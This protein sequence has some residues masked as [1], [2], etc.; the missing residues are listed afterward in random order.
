MLQNKNLC[1]QGLDKKRKSDPGAGS[2]SGNSNILV[3]YKAQLDDVQVEEINTPILPASSCDKRE[4]E[5]NQSSSESVSSCSS[6]KNVQN[7]GVEQNRDSS[8]IKYFHS[9]FKR[10]KTV[11]SGSPISSIPDQPVVGSDNR[12]YFSDWKGRFTKKVHELRESKVGRD[13]SFSDKD[14]EF[15]SPE[16]SPTAKS[17]DD[18]TYLSCGDTNNTDDIKSE[19][20]NLTKAKRLEKL[21]LY[22]DSKL[23]SQ[24]GSKSPAPANTNETNEKRTEKELDKSS[25]EEK[26]SLGKKS[27]APTK[28]N[29][30]I[31]SY[32]KNRKRSYLI[33]GVVDAEKVEEA[34]EATV[35]YKMNQPEVS[36][37]IP[38]EKPLS[39]R[40]ISIEAFMLA[41]N[42]WKVF[43]G[44]VFFFFIH[45]NT[46]GYVSA[47]FAGFI[48][49]IELKNVIQMLQKMCGFQ[50]MNCSDD[51]LFYTAFLNEEGVPVLSDSAIFNSLPEK[52]VHQ[53]WMNE[54]MDGDYSS[55]CFQLSRTETVY[56]HLDGPILFISTPR[57]KIPKRA[58]WNE[59][60]Y[61]MLFNEKRM[62][63]ITDCCVDLVPEGLIRKRKWSRRFPIRIKLLPHSFIGACVRGKGQSTISDDATWVPAANY[64][65]RSA[66]DFSLNLSRVN[67]ESTMN[68]SQSKNAK[69]ASHSADSE[70]FRYKNRDGSIVMQEQPV[71]NKS[72]S[73]SPPSVRK[74]DNL[75]G[76]KMKSTSVDNI[77]R[78]VD[79][80]FVG[81]ESELPPASS[82][83]QL[84]DDDEEFFDIEKTDEEEMGKESRN[85]LSYRGKKHIISSDEET[86]LLKR[87]CGFKEG[88]VESSSSPNQ[89]EGHLM[90]ED[91][92]IPSSQKKMSEEIQYL[93]LFCRTNR[94]KEAWF[95]Y[96]SAA[97]K[98]KIS[99]GETKI[100]EREGLKVA[101]NSLDGSE[102]PLPVRKSKYLS[103][104]YNLQQNIVPKAPNDISIVNEDDCSPDVEIQLMWL[105]AIIGRVTHEF[106]KNSLICSLIKNKIQQ[107]LRL[108]SLPRF[109]DALNVS[110]L[111]IEDVYPVIKRASRPTLDD[112][113]IWVDLDVVYSGSSKLAIDTKLNLLKL[114]KVDAKTPISTSL[115]N[116]ISPQVPLLPDDLPESLPRSAAFHSDVES[117]SSG[118]SSDEDK[119]L[120]MAL[121]AELENELG[122]GSNPSSKPRAQKKT[123]QK[124]LQFV[125]KFTSTKIFESFIENKYVKRVVENVSNTD[126]S[127]MVELKWLCGTLVINIPPPPA[128]RIWIGF[129]N[130]PKMVLSCYPRF[131][132]TE[133]SYM[134]VSK[135]IRKLLIREMEKNLVL[136]NMEDIL[137][138]SELF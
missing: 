17:F 119:L 70:N 101:S 136:P 73:R 77:H 138:P 132:E 76:A 26:K 3:R 21:S 94:Q 10:S 65:S 61:K 48:L 60:Q 82:S 13:S 79:E 120:E 27:S 38:K 75:K 42:W 64:V 121:D 34:E 128:D 129:R 108:V 93:Y 85:Q 135:W 98:F 99:H 66:S 96:L 11:D 125:D 4:E 107:K 53:D 57:F 33:K 90:D 15:L 83:A 110:N 117:E 102:V 50:P 6:P 14:P 23:I 112:R 41:V 5:E 35:H 124:V 127:L 114:K 92:D 116:L 133:V 69:G 84:D 106:S 100:E 54:L 20:E 86:L 47:F 29:P 19:T 16:P 87:L 72:F 56:V 104:M 55:E 97:T 137:L 122:S 36:R 2:S 81:S 109:M 63:V 30:S 31:R 111:E 131:G 24:D 130:N 59:P 1:V 45:Y 44:A 67:S 88:Q 118:N 49:S 43:F 134:E 22:L 12:N 89:L 62:Y 95:R 103:Y 74:Q 9:R 51:M 58:V 68:E 115:T 7:D 52:I 37:Q 71:Q 8:P 91:D 123:G 126:L 105:N 32:F 46:P 78:K 18:P 80:F 113:G 25:N 28:S 39:R 40:K